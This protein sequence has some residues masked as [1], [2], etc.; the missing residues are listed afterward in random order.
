LTADEEWLRGNP[1]AE[2]EDDTPPEATPRSVSTGSTT[3]EPPVVDELEEISA[4]DPDLESTTVVGVPVVL[5]VLGGKVIAE[6]LD[7][8]GAAN[9]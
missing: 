5:E 7:E 2:P 8:P 4:D 1:V 3:R 6:E 9:V